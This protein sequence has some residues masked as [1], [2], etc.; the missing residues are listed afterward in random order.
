MFLVTVL[1]VKLP[2]FFVFFKTLLLPL[3]NSGCCSCLSCSCC[4]S[5]IGRFAA[6][7]RTITQYHCAILVTELL[8][9]LQESIVAVDKFGLLCLFFVEFFGH[10][11]ATC[12]S[13]MLQRRVAA[14]VPTIVQY[15]CAIL[16]TLLGKLP[17]CFIPE[18]VVDIDKFW[19]VFSFFVGAIVT[20]LLE[21]QCCATLVQCS[22]GSNFVF[23][24]FF[25]FSFFFSFPPF[26]LFFS[27]LPF[28]FPFFQVWRQQTQKIW[29]QKLK[30]GLRPAFNSWP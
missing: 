30:R 28:L 29:N 26:F 13:D 7:V 18:S 11:A 16:V 4:D 15:R 24:P 17:F 23:F 10:V 1:L 12:C 21:R 3:T 14:T 19:L 6:G 25:P 20:V 9:L 5:V 8:F 22:I 27:F 2:H